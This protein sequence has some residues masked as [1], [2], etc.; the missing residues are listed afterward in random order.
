MKRGLYRGAAANRR[1]PTLGGDEQRGDASTARPF[2]ALARFAAAAVAAAC[3][4]A[5]GAADAMDPAAGARAEIITLGTNAGPVP[6]PRRS[7]PAL[8]L[9]TGGD[10]ILIDAGDGVSQQLGKAN[11]D[12]G[13]IR[14]VLIS[15]LHFDHTGGLFAFLAL[16]YH[17]MNT[18]EITIYGPP[19]VK[20]LIAGL[21]ASMNAATAGASDMRVRMPFAPG[22]NIK[23]V[24]VGDGSTFT[25]GAVRITAAANSHFA[26]S[27]AASDRPR[28]L[29]L[30]FRFDTPGRS[31]VYTGDTG[32]SENVE[33]LARGA[34]ILFC[35]VFDPDAAL[36]T[37]KSKRPDLPTGTL[38]R[39]S[40]H[41]RKEHLQPTDVGLLAARADVGSVV[42]VHDAIEPRG[43]AAAS[44]AIAA[45]YRGS[46]T[47]ADDLDR[48]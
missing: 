28:E 3:L 26:A 46:I 40:A 33:K 21:N 1:A 12:L 5:A 42:L 45:H 30:S 15:H 25:V 6:N 20:G 23:V 35:E 47:F 44:R 27:V 37:L 38:E 8:L 29:S 14:T 34:D 22:A 4:T 48:F 7:E 31:I 41:F 2:P 13:S 18:G 16:N 39:V 10:N 43:L 11:V 17:L 24:E 9:R 36:A 19:G 32:P